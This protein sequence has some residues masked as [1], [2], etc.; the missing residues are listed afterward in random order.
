MY[1]SLNTV[2]CNCYCNDIAM[3]YC[4]VTMNVLQCAHILICGPVFGR[5]QRYPGAT[6]R[7]PHKGRKGNVKKNGCF[8]KCFV[9]SRTRTP[10]GIA[11]GRPMTTT[12]TALLPSVRYH[13]RSEIGN[14]M[15][16]GPSHGYTAGTL[17]YLSAVCGNRG[18][19]IRRRRRRGVARALRVGVAALAIRRRHRRLGSYRRS[20]RQIQRR[21]SRDDFPRLP[22]RRHRTSSVDRS[23]KTLRGWPVHRFVTRRVFPTGRS[24]NYVRA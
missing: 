24:L 5:E 17:R 11:S 13:L 10:S 15:K 9:V 23:P 21:S 3:F 4:Y 12:P 14:P 18:V 22:R 1:W 7:L 16:E 20:H 19:D 6:E 8:S 2:E